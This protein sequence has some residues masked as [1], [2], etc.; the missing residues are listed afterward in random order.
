MKWRAE[1]IGPLCQYREHSDR[2]QGT[3]I[4]LRRQCC[5]AN[6]VTWPGI[7][8]RTLHRATA[9]SLLSIF[10]AHFPP[11]RSEQNKPK[12]QQTSGQRSYARPHIEAGI[13]MQP[14]DA[15]PCLDTSFFTLHSQIFQPIPPPHLPSPPPLHPPSASPPWRSSLLPRHPPPWYP[16]ESPRS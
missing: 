3:R 9:S 11:E 4:Q 5:S 12:S 16:R 14:Q 2:K 13:A 7:S 8:G 6:T 1:W 10:G 15:T